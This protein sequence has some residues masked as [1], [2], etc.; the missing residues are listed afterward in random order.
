MV[1]LVATPREPVRHESVPLSRI[2][3]DGNVDTCGG[4]K[5]PIQRFDANLAAGSCANWDHQGHFKSLPGRGCKVR[6]VLHEAEVSHIRS[7]QLTR[8]GP[9]KES[10]EEPAEK[11]RVT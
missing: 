2:L 4:V 5:S 7:H 11:G 9:G 3:L 6:I 1:W 10:L 8:P